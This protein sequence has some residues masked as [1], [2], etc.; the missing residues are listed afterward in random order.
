M[1]A[2]SNDKG[3]VTI[4][5]PENYSEKTIVVSHLTIKNMFEATQ[6]EDLKVIYDTLDVKNGVAELKLDKAGAARYS[7]EPS[8]LTTLQPE[9]YAEP[10]EA[11]T[12]TIKSFEPL[13]YDVT[14]SKLM[15]DIMAYNKVINPI[16]QEYM[17][18]VGRDSAIDPEEIQE[19]MKRYDDALKKFVADNPDSPALPLVII[20]LGADDF[21]PIYDNLSAKAKKSILMPYAEAYNKDVEEMLKQREEEE[22][23]KAEVASGKITAPGFTLPDLEG[24]KVSL[25]DFKGKW[26]VLDFWGSW[27]GWCIK[28][29]P[30]LKEAYQKYGDRIVVIGIDCNESEADWRE[31]VKKH[32]LPWINVYNGNDQALYEAYNIT[33]FPTKA[34]INPEGKLVDL[35]TGE[36]PAFFTRLAEFMK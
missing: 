6:V 30:A 17:A 5:L 16:Q 23:R 9:F 22:A 13:D 19:H 15:E 3:T 27:C 32:E 34:I 29:F 24:K 20:D 31:G 36:D 10:N 4:Q 2:C 25:S 1:A 26:V 28:G 8:V 35:T 33:G 12:V 18:L 11:L 14:G 7:I 21:K